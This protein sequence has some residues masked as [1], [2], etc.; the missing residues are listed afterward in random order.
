MTISV[1]P[2]PA[3]ATTAA[4]LSPRSLVRARRVAAVRG[5]ASAFRRDPL[6][7][8]GIGVLVLFAAVALDSIL[9]PLW[10]RPSRAYPLGTD[11]LGRSVAAQ[12]VWGSRVSLLVGVAAALLAVAIGSI[13]GLASGF[14]GGDERHQIWRNAVFE[15]DDVQHPTAADERVA[16]C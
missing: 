16:L 8:I 3:D 15:I 1:I 9:N 2:D 5:F 10:A 6:A 4:G 7:M 12:F 14:F 11:N 13:V